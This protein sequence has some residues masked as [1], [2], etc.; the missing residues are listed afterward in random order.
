VSRG[1]A[2]WRRALSEPTRCKTKC[3]T[4]CDAGGLGGSDPLHRYKLD[5]T[6]VF[7]RSNPLHLALQGSYEALHGGDRRGKADSQTQR[8]KEGKARRGTDKI[9]L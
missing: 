5:F 3:R 7:L 4:K 1:E 9:M 6:E 2:N 8:R